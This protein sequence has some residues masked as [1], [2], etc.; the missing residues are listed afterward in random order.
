MTTTQPCHC[1]YQQHQ[2]PGIYCALCH[3]CL[4]TCDPRAYPPNGEYDPEYWEEIH[5]A[6]N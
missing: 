3:E 1:C 5:H 2:E 6:D 4:G